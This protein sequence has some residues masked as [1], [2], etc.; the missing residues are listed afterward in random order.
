M[1]HCSHAHWRK[2]CHISD[3]SSLCFG[4]NDH[5]ICKSWS[6]LSVIKMG[7]TTIIRPWAAKIIAM[8]CIYTC[9]VLAYVDSVPAL[10]LTPFSLPLPSTRLRNRWTRQLSWG[11]SM[12]RLSMIRQSGWRWLSTGI[13]RLISSNRLI[14]SQYISAWYYQVCRVDRPHKWSRDKAPNLLFLYGKTQQQEIV[15]FFL[16]L[17]W[18]CILR[19]D[20]SMSHGF[21]LL[22][23]FTLIINSVDHPLV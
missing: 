14:N 9:V 21:D 17:K 23:F 7:T 2:D 20:L 5:Q 13:T 11:F 12:R 22:S 10:H 3:C 16:Q 15:M 1:I 8:A 4:I 6:C 18:F 19:V